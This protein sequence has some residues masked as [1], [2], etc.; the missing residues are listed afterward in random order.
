MFLFHASLCSTSQPQRH[1]AYVS[2]A[3]PSDTRK[4]P[5]PPLW[6]QRASHGHKTRRCIIP[7]WTSAFF[8]KT[9]TDPLCASKYRAYMNTFIFFRCEAHTIFSSHEA[10]TAR[11]HNYTIATTTTTTTNSRGI[12]TG[13]RAWAQAGDQ[14]RSECEPSSDVGAETAGAALD[15][16]TVCD[17]HETHWLTEALILAYKWGKENL[18]LIRYRHTLL[19]PIWSN[20]V[21]KLRIS[22]HYVWGW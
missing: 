21:Y 17:S 22:L 14:H 9:N 11:P 6:R 13:C 10:E 12:G 1:R 16:A 2:P 5:V 19:K 15:V 20:L 4:A 18:R 7:F 8:T 3:S